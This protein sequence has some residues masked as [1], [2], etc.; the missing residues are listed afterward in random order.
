MKCIL[1]SYLV[2]IIIHFRIIQK[3]Q[4]MKAKIAKK[5]FKN[6]MITKKLQNVNKV[7]LLTLL[8][9]EQR[10]TLQIKQLAGNKKYNSF[11]NH[12]KYFK[13]YNFMLCAFVSITI[14]LLLHFAA[15]TQ[16]R[17][18][19]SYMFQRTALVE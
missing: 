14:Y 19:V 18:Y 3:I 15:Y 7:G 4:S 9:K 5:N 10:T 16:T 13:H 11:Q 17:T 1:H 2:S 8:K 6:V 12:M